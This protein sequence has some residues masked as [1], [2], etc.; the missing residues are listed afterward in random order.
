V[1]LKVLAPVG[2]VAH[3]LTDVPDPVFAE[4]IVGPG[5]AVEPGADGTT[6]GSPINGT[7]VKVKPHAFVVVAEDGR[8]VLVHLGIDTVKLA[9]EGF[10]VLRAEGETVQAGDPVIRWHPDAIRASG[11]SAICPVVALDATGV[12]DIAVGGISAGDSLFTWL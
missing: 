12:E 10:E 7:L 6:V 5:A 9:G 4:A 2:G 8:G 1:A 11:L 3:P